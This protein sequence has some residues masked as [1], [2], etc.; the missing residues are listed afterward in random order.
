M[1]L[2]I[3]SSH[4]LLAILEVLESRPSRDVAVCLLKLTNIVGSS[5]AVSCIDSDSLALS[6]SRLTSLCWRVFVFWGMFETSSQTGIALPV[7]LRSGIPI[8]M[9]RSR[10]HSSAV[11]INSSGKP[12]PA[13]NTHSNVVRKHLNL[14]NYSATRHC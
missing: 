12:S 7:Y 2:Q 1:Q 10:R 5:L 13:R 3:V 6:L 4:G 11:V 14:C 8:V 9:S